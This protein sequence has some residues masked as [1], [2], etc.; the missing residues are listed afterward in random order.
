VANF[1]TNFS[2]NFYRK[3][4]S[5]RIVPTVPRCKIKLLFRKP[6]WVLFK[7]FFRTLSESKVSFYNMHWSDIWHLHISIFD[8]FRRKFQM[9]IFLYFLFHWKYAKILNFDANFRYY[10]KNFCAEI[11]RCLVV[12]T[13][14]FFQSCFTESFMTSSDLFCKDHKLLRVLCR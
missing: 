2:R 1:F 12:C 8:I 11:V 9:E 4:G 10:N 5:L 13:K 14:T 3:L 7:S 6:F